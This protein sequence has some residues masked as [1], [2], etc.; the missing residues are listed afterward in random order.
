M[1]KIVIGL[2][3]SYAQAQSAVKDL[4]D[5]G[6]DRSR[7]GVAGAP[8]G[9]KEAVTAAIAAGAGTALVGTAGL[10]MALAPVAIPGIGWIIAAGTIA[11]ALVGA[12]VAVA[13]N[14]LPRLLAAMGIP[15]AD[16]QAYAEGMRRGG[17]IVTV[18]AA[19]DAE[20]ELAASIIQ[21]HGA[22]DIG[23]RADEWKRGG[24]SGR[25]ADSDEQQP[26]APVVVEELVVVGGVRIYTAQPEP[27]VDRRRSKLPFTGAERRK[28]A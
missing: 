2:M 21:Q 14:K 27:E 15:E 1:A 6:I 25:V 13:A 10:A 22:V 20:A 18:Q 17:T 16:A 12:G 4:L 23:E 24:W 8:Q 7:I 3:D 26:I 5:A 28:A 9:S 19:N 11:A